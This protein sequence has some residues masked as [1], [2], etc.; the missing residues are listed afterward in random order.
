MMILSKKFP[1][2]AQE[3]EIFI[4]YDEVNKQFEEVKNITLRKNGRWYPVGNIMTKLFAEAVCKLI[5]TTD[6]EEV[7]E[8]QEQNKHKLSDLLHPVM[9]MTLNPF[10]VTG[11]EVRDVYN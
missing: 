7:R 5:T 2:E 9:A 8:E 4:K 11:G 10:V 6:W 3:F 1:H